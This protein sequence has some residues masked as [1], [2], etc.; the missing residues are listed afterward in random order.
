MKFEWLEVNAK[1]H[2]SFQVSRLGL[3]GLQM[4]LFVNELHSFSRKRQP[5]TRRHWLSVVFHPYSRQHY[6]RPAPPGLNPLSLF[7]QSSSTTTTMDLCITMTGRWIWRQNPEDS[8]CV[9]YLGQYVFFSSCGF[10]S[11][12]GSISTG[13]VP[14]CLF[15]VNFD[16]AFDCWNGARWKKLIRWITLTL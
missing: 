12:F 6:C 14:G 5:K 3:R 1:P 11:F 4:W 13:L 15:S 9:V 16:G 8:P 2:I 10:P 7:V